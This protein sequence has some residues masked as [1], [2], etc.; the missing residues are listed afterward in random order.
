MK[1]NTITMLTNV[2]VGLFLIL[3]IFALAIFFFEMQNVNSF[4]Q[5]V[6]YTIERNGGLNQNIVGEL[7]QHSADFFNGRFEVRGDA[8]D[9]SFGDVIDYQVDVQIPISFLPVPDFQTTFTG[10]APSMVR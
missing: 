8:S 7:N 9:V 4:R 5:T 6:N 1:E 10:T 2:F 3:G